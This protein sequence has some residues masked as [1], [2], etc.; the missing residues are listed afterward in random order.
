VLF[1]ISFFTQLVYVMLVY[2][3]NVSLQFQGTVNTV[4]LYRHPQSH[5]SSQAGVS[6]QPIGSSHSIGSSQPQWSSSK[7]V[8]R[9]INIVMTVEKAVKVIRKIG[10]SWNCKN[11]RAAILLFCFFACV[12]VVISMFFYIKQFVVLQCDGYVF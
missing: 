6:S 10:R 11:T 3:L 1:F 5:L 12:I 9:G 4:R 7:P 2:C 8:T